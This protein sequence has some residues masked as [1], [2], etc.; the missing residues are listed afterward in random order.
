MRKASKS[1]FGILTT[2]SSRDKR[3]APPLHQETLKPETQ[4]IKAPGSHFGILAT[5]TS[6]DEGM[7]SSTTLG[8]PETRNAKCKSV[9][10]PFRYFGYWEFKEQRFIFVFSVLE[11]LH[12][13]SS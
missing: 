3:A 9:Q 1:Y 10:E 11:T 2:G 8:N 12:G 13:R 6:K 5:G 7:F 4:N